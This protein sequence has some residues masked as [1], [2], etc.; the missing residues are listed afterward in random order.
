MIK[1]FGEILNCIMMSEEVSSNISN[2]YDFASG[3][4]EELHLLETISGSYL[5]I[6]VVIL[7]HQRYDIM[8]ILL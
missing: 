2:L 3:Q 7:I 5:G 8:Y 6:I 1:T 4:L